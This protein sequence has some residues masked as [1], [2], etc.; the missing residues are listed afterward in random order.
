MHIDAYSVTAAIVLFV[1]MI[2][3]FVALLDIYL[4]H[5]DFYKTDSSDDLAKFIE[6]MKNKKSN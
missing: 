1:L 5:T 2:G 4:W 3:C 6:E